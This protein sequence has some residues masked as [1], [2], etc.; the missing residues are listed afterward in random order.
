MEDTV[1][2]L[3]GTQG[4]ELLL[5]TDK[6]SGENFTILSSLVSK[7][8]NRKVCSWGV[9]KTVEPLQPMSGVEWIVGG[10]SA[11]LMAAIHAIRSA[12]FFN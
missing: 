6:K 7:Q 8:V 10:I 1:D 4:I 5:T 9:G 12:T 11:A 2:H 3:V